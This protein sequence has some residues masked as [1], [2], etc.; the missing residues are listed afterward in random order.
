MSDT[1]HLFYGKEFVF[2][3]KEHAYFWD[4]SPIPGVTTILSVIAKP[5]LMPWA[6]K[7]TRDYWLQ[8]LQSGRTDHDKIHKESWN[9][10]KNFSKAAA[11]IGSNVHEYAECALKG[12][13][14]PVLKTEEAKRGADAFHKWQGAHKIKLLASERF[15]FSLK[16]YYAGTCDLI[17]EI[18]GEYCV[19]D[20]K[21]SSGIYPEMRLQTAAYQGAIQEENGVK[22]DARWIIRFDKT[23]GEFEAK[24]FTD[25]DLD[26]AGFSSALSLHKVLQSIRA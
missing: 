21:T 26:F 13:P 6:V 1:K 20:F 3:E 4:G 11:D 24:R 10:H 2:D 25:F 19:G 8:A 14:L 5:A 16:N 7:M 12:L 9:A 18:D 15:V 17:A 22:V 23:T